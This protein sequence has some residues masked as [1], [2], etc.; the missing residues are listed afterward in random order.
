MKDTD[1][2]P[3]CGAEATHRFGRIEYRCGSYPEEQST[4]CARITRLERCL[5]FFASAIKCGEPWSKTCEDEY[6]AAASSSPQ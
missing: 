6:L 4:V 5:A 1:K 2:C 3:W